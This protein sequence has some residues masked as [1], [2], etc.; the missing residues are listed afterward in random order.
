MPTTCPIC[1][2]PMSLINPTTC[3]NCDYQTTWTQTEITEYQL[4][5][6]SDAAMEADY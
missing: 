2:C 6:A 1:H 5:L 4:M 3:Q